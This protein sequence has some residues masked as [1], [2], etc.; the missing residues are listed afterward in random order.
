MRAFV[1]VGSAI[2]C[3]LLIIGVWS[4]YCTTCCNG[5][6][7]NPELRVNLETQP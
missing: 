1:C 4:E 6:P 7:C 5:E 3:A 2:I